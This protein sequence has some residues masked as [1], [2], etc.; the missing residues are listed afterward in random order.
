MPSQ[1][2]PFILIDTNQFQ[3]KSEEEQKQIIGNGIYSVVEHSYQPYAGKITA[4]ILQKGVPEL[5]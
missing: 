3:G 1:V 2:I 5:L 4:M